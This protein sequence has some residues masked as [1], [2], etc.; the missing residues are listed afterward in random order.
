[1]STILNSLE[2]SANNVTSLFN[3][4]CYATIFTQEIK[5]KISKIDEDLKASAHQLSLD[6]RYS[7]THYTKIRFL[8]NMQEEL[9]REEARIRATLLL[10]E[11]QGMILLNRDALDKHI[12]HAKTLLHDNNFSIVDHMMELSVEVQITL[13]ASKVLQEN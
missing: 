9:L 10:V 12:A 6:P 13:H 8:T 7:S 4:L 1:M 2:T 11:I 3:K 5:D